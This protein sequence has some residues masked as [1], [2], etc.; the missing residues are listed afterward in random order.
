MS[1]DMSAMIRTGVTLVLVA[2]LISAVLNIVSIATTAISTGMNTLQSGVGRLNTQ[3]F[4]TYNQTTLT[5]TEV[6]AAINLYSNRDVA[7]CIQTNALG[8]RTGTINYNVGTY[9]NYGALVL[10][11]GTSVPT[12]TD[13]G[14][15]KVYK[16]TATEGASGGSGT[17]TGLVCSDDKSKFVSTLAVDS[18]QDL[19]FN[20]TTSPVKN[21]GM[22]NSYVNPTGKFK[23]RLIYDDS[24]AIIGIAFTQLKN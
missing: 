7:I 11:S 20:K 18:N 19:V 22:A 5:G 12:G 14:G 1:E 16:V 21:K 6:L 10:A 2:A 3:E 23:S 24:G 4:E 9:H 15:V 17:S 8:T 13:E